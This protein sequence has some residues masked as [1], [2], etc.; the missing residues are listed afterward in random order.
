MSSGSDIELGDKTGLGSSKVYPYDGPPGTVATANG[1]SDSEVSAKPREVAASKFGWPALSGSSSSSDSSAVNRKKS[2]GNM[3]GKTK[4]LRHM[5]SS[6][7]EGEDGEG[8]E[9][10]LLGTFKGVFVPTAQNVLGIIL[11]IRLPFIT[12][13]AGIGETLGIVGISCFATT[14]TSIS[15]SAIAT[16]GRIEGGGSYSIIRKSLGPEFGGTVGLLLFISNTFGVAMYCF[17]AVEVLSDISDDL[18][19]YKPQDKRIIGSFVL[20]ALTGIVFIGIKYIARFAVLFLS[21]VLIS[22]FSIFVGAFVRTANP[23]KSEGILGLSADLFEE[24][25]GSDYDSNWDFASCLALF[26]PAVTDPLAGSN[27]SG[28][29]KDPTGSIPKGTLMAVLFTSMIFFLQV[30]L[31]GGSVTRETLKNNKLIV[32]KIAWPFAEVIM[33][34]VLVSTLGAGLQS[35]AGAPRLM[36]AIARDNV[37]NQ[38]SI[39][40]C[41]PGEEPRKALFLTYSISQCAL[42]LGSLDVVAPFITMFFLTCYAIMNGACFLL[43]YEKSPSFRPRWHYFHWSMSLAGLVTCLC[44]MFMIRWYFAL[45][46]LGI[47]LGLYKY[48]QYVRAYQEAGGISSG[49]SDWS[50]GIRFQQVRKWLLALESA[51]FELKYWRPFVLFLCEVEPNGEYK[52]QKGMINLI[53]QIM[54][55]GKGIAVMSAVIPGDYR[56]KIDHCNQGNQFLK[57]ALR[58]AEVE[59]F[60]SCITAESKMEGLRHLIQGN[61]FTSLK[62]NTVMLGLPVLHPLTPEPARPEFGEM[63][64]TSKTMP[65]PSLAE[66]DPVKKEA[67]LKPPSGSSPT[68]PPHDTHMDLNKLDRYTVSQMETTAKMYVDLLDDITHSGKS[69]LICT[70][71]SDFLHTGEYTSTIDVWWLFDLLPAKGLLLLIPYLLMFHKCWKKCEIRLLLATCDPEDQEDMHELLMSLIQKAGLSDKIK[72]V[73]IVVCTE[74]EALPFMSFDQQGNLHLPNMDAQYNA[75]EEKRGTQFIM[76]SGQSKAGEYG[77]LSSMV[78]TVEQSKKDIGIPSDESKYLGKRRSVCMNDAKDLAGPEAQDPEKDAGAKDSAIEA[79]LAP[80]AAQDSLV[81]EDEFAEMKQR[82]S[83]RKKFESKIQSQKRQRQ[84]RIILAGK[85][86]TGFST[87]V[88]AETLNKKILAES[89]NSEFGGYEHAEDVA[90]AERLKLPHVCQQVDSKL[91]EGDSGQR[92]RARAN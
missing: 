14:L 26:Y 73:K 76:G 34:G 3:G 79:E 16:N 59:G 32:T 71:V 28:D 41:A 23:W 20:I 49:G 33:G 91:A 46:V 52:R 6:P 8:K 90:R 62:P 74:E 9:R 64:D 35:L 57:E 83:A 63:L 36:Q 60:A 56:E 19:V 5:L 82:V 39:F 89:A 1:G 31:A 2:S 53:S 69:V 10:I 84:R 18:S 88:E 38:L 61:C 25:L 47:S 55:R 70:G 42:M 15:M 40:K 13:Q 4:T 12:G 65:M 44:L 17:G 29:L 51:D 50:A 67:E 54:Y 48:C 21:G 30:L 43:A 78:E 37:I 75:M 7:G 85:K 11:F 27:L 68:P 58:E 81:N 66:E 77:S 86:Q 92:E 87:S 24:N 80:A 22:I 45:I 72:E